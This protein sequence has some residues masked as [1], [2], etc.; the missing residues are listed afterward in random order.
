MENWEEYGQCVITTENINWNTPEWDETKNGKIG[1]KISSQKNSSKHLDFIDLRVTNS[2]GDEI[3]LTRIELGK[4]K[5]IC[6][7]VTEIEN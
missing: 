7:W 4:L 6:E 1:I 2:A 3:E 5:S